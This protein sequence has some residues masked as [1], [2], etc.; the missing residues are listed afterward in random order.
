MATTK[1]AAKPVKTAKAAKP[2]VAFSIIKTM[3]EL[4][5]AIASIANRSAKLDTDIHRAAVSVIHHSALH[6]D[7]DVAKRLVASLGKSMRRNGMVAWLCNYGAFTTDDAGELVYVKERRDAVMSDANIKAATD[8]PFWEFSPE[9]QYRQF[10]LVKAMAA[11]LAKAEH[12]MTKNEQDTALIP[13]DK[14]AA[15]RAIAAAEEQAAA[16]AAAAEAASATP[17]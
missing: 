4:N 11:L 9:P 13:P 2:A 1:Q 3:P 6:N 7:P 12:A 16:I 8:E 5:K 17:V 14:L 15:L 10:D